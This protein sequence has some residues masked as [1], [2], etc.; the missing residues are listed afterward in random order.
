MKKQPAGTGQIDLF[1]QFVTNGGDE[2]SNTVELWESIPK[3][4]TPTRSTTLRT[5]DGLALPYE[6]KYNH[7]GHSCRVVITPAII[8][9][10][11]GKYKACYPSLTE[12]LVEDALKRILI[13][14]RQGF[15]D[16]ASKT[17]RV[18]FTLRMIQRQLNGGTGRNGRQRSIAEIKHSI[19]VMHLCNIKYERGDG[20][21]YSGSILNDLYTV[22]L[23]DFQADNTAQHAARLPSLIHDS[24]ERLEFRQFNYQRLIE[25][26]TQLSRWIYKQL[27]NHYKQADMMNNYHFMFT[28]IQQHSGLL[29][30]RRESDNRLKLSTA[31]DELVKRGVLSR[32]T[33]TER[34]E[35]RKIVDV[36]YKAY[37]TRTFISEQ[38]AA[39]KRHANN[40]QLL[41]S[42]VDNSQQ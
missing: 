2:L 18:L 15:H 8:K 4:A 14:Q 3:Y 27:V 33:T 41:G 40:R 12:E 29:Q 34:R 9:Q 22:G 10:S 39:N 23:S 20:I 11:N 17:T 35:G 38:K 16:P 13:E 25:C 5:D 19:Q 6:W 31:L 32:Y 28:T 7:N 1:R 24:I 21:S 36:K 30:Q 37:P 42:P 26:N